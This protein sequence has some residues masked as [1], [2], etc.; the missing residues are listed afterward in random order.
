MTDTRKFVAAL[1]RLQ[2]AALRV[3]VV[4]RQLLAAH[5]DLP[6][7]L[8]VRPTAQVSDLRGDAQ[9]YLQ[10]H[11]NDDAR[12]WAD[13]LGIELV[14]RLDPAPDY[15]PGEGDEH[16]DGYTVIDGVKVHVGSVRFIEP[17]EWAAIQA[18]ESVPAGGETV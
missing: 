7:L 1:D 16:A 12:V 17:D 11:T 10:P 9:L 4:A 8:A 5:T 2:A 14:T 3:S 13:R 6:P 18:A 15:R